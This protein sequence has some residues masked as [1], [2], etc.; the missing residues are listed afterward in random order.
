MAPTRITKVTE[1]LR[2]EF[3]K[4][5][6]LEMGD[7]L[8]QAHNRMAAVEDE[9][10][11]MKAQIKDKKAGLEQII[12]R[13]ARNLGNGF[14]MR[15]VDC[16]LVYDSP[17]VGEVTFRRKDNG[18]FVKARPMTE[19]ERQMDLP[20]EEKSDAVAEASAGE[21]AANAEE[22]FKPGRPTEQP[23]AETAAPVKEEK[24]AKSK[25]QVN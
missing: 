14:E 15:N 8:A 3:T 2:H 1:Y 13:L 12:G 4:E 16:E 11:V 5:E 20:L 7:S 24:P 10:A 17:N 9:E 23:T 19:T 25:K 21:S 22:F 18:E 6:R